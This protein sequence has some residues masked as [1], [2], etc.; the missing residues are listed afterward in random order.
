MS[1]L[2]KINH[3]SNSFSSLIFDQAN[4]IF[5]KNNFLVVSK[6]RAL[7]YVLLPFLVTTFSILIY[8][9]LHFWVGRLLGAVLTSLIGSGHALYFSTEILIGIS[10]FKAIAFKEHSNCFFLIPNWLNNSLFIVSCL[11]GLFLGSIVYNL[12]W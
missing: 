11:N 2:K 9:F 7:I 12:F 1:A 3:I 10:Q 4:T 6:S 5:P 8:Y